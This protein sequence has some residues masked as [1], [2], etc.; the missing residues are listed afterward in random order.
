MARKYFEFINR[1]FSTPAARY[2]EHEVQAEAK[3]YDFGERL[4][5]TQYTAAAMTRLPPW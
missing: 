1:L 5:A 4:E 3:N 2:T